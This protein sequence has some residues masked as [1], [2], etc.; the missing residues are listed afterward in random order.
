MKDNNMVNI[1]G[2]ELDRVL[3]ER[4]L[5][6]ATLSR[7]MGY[8]K[9]YVKNAISQGKIRMAVVEYLKAIYNIEPELY[10]K[11]EREKVDV[12]TYC[13][14]CGVCIRKNDLL[15]KIYDELKI[16]S[17]IENQLVETVDELINELK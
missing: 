4:G 11:T 2:N 13:E 12:S 16:L 6:K 14:D 3:K 17:N 7:K 9:G 5:Q 8:S 10:V 1:N 15:D